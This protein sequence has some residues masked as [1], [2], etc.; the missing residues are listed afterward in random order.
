MDKR[1]L[2]LITF[3]T[4]DEFDKNEQSWARYSDE[5]EALDVYVRAASSAVVQEAV[6]IE[7]TKTVRHFGII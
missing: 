1:W 7:G 4:R 2:V 5:R 6:L 3:R